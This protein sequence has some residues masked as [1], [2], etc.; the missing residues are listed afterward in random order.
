MVE[1][2]QQDVERDLVRCLAALGA[3]DERDHA[4]EERRALFGGDAHH[5]PVGHDLRAAG[6]GRTVAAGFTD[7]GRAFAGDSTLVDRG[8]ALHDLAIRG[9]EVVGLDQHQISL[10]KVGRRGRLPHL[11][12]AR[13]ED[14]LCHRIRARPAHA[15]GARPATALGHRLGEGR[16]E[17][18]EPEPNGDGERKGRAMTVEDALDAHDRCQH[19]DDLGHEDHGVLHQGARVEFQD[20]R[21]ARPWR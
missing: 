2:G 18:S 7:D 10:A 16:E 14:E 4:V 8:D 17:H 12:L 21:H 11:R 19:G 9:N 5:E 6:D 1:A 13:I 15:F 3:L 20:P